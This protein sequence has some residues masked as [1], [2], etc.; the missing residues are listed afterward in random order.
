MFRNTLL[1]LLVAATAGDVQAAPAVFWAGD[2][3]R[4]GET[5][6]LIGE[7]FGE[8]PQVEVA[9]LPDGAPGAP[10]GARVAWP[11]AGRRAEVLQAG[12]QC[13]KF[14]VPAALKP[15]AFAY[16]VTGPA[17][18]TVGILNRPAIWWA[19]G[20][21][22]PA[23]SPGGRVRVLG[24]NLAAPGGG[25]GEWESGRVGEGVKGSAGR[26]AA[27]PA[28]IIALSGPT[29]VRLPAEADAY[30]A[31]AELPRK[32]PG[33]QYQLSFHNGCGG[34]SAWSESVRFAVAKRQP[35][36]DKAFNVRDFGADPTGA[37]DSTPAIQ[38]ALAGAKDGGVL[39]FPRGRYRVTDTIGVPRFTTLRG[40]AR[41]TTSLFWPDTEKPPKALVR[42]TNTFAVESLT[43]YASNHANVIVA[44]QTEPDAGDVAIRRVRVRADIYRGHLKPE[45]VHARF[46]ASLANSTGGSDSLRL[47]G[48]NVEVTDCDIYG[49][50]R[51]LFLSRV[52]G[53][54]IAGNT[55]YN[56]RWGW[57][58]ISG[59]DGLVFENNRI[60]GGDLQ[61]TG[62][63]LNC[64]DGSTCSQNVYYARNS[65][66]LMHG[67][68]REAMTSDAGGGCYYGAVASSLGS[69]V[70]LAEEPT[71]GG[72]AWAGAARFLL[73]GRGRGQYRQIV[74][75]EGKTVTLDRPWLVPPDATTTAS[76]TMLQRHY[77]FVGN[78][79]TDAGVALQ[80]YGMAIEDI[81]DGNVSTR[82]AGFH[83]FGMNYHG[84]QPSWY[85]QW[86]NNEIREGN[87]YRSGHDNYMLA[88]EAHLG[89]FGF[90]PFADYQHPITLGCVARGNALRNNAHIAIGGSDP[91]NPG[92]TLPLV[93]E[94][95]VENNSI[96]NSDV[97]I[98]LRRASRGVLLRNN[99]FQAVKEPVRDQEAAVKAAA[100]RRKQLALRREP[101]AVW[102]FEGLTATQAPD[103]TGNRF[104]ARLT[105]DVAA[106]EG[107]RGKAA[108][109]AGQSYLQVHDP[110]TFNL[111]DV[112]L[113]LWIKPDTVQGRHGLLSK[114]F[115]E[116][117][118]PYIVS[119]WD[120][121]LE[122][123]ATDAKGAWSFNFRAPAHLKAGEWAHV[124]VV[125]AAGKGVTLYANG[126][127]VGRKENPLERA[128]NGEPL[129]F[130]REAWGGS[131]Q[132]H[133]P[134]YYLGLM[135]DV[136]V[137]ARALS[138]EE[139]L[140]EFAGGG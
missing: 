73:D 54:R 70:T 34:A 67:W 51:A 125:A 19:Q 64:L 103:A 26:S 129:V 57:Y 121:D 25:V 110:E 98:S 102:D 130:G 22:G 13:V 83:N 53:G 3:I 31:W 118:A 140:R 105:G 99:R 9:R 134:C 113:S 4:P 59:S 97:G 74:R 111:Q 101:L 24:K 7:G 116:S 44:D 85:I 104:H 11:G 77:L 23:G 21:L 89:I 108:R 8:K 114:R 139:V 61:A 107:H 80:L 91:D 2:P 106:A 126:R 109:F 117:G 119:L 88:G 55:F 5:A 65:L 63:G 127:P 10:A 120:G 45:E 62:G 135:D 60:I 138:D 32:L 123:E 75:I 100:E 50:G 68:D 124:A 48:R 132:V 131:H 52:R 6:L 96:A 49:S 38:A 78:D 36:P 37:N 95:V 72:R 69:Q 18:A 33:G 90:P 27:A 81:A 20:D 94:V 122:F 115:V 35:W 137:W 16:R 29:T 136:K 40:E 58:C 71:A 28:P 92:L 93:Q 39:F 46:T 84:V 17:G 43:L 128:T 86:L 79:F 76:I 30:S 87:S 112:T 42:G 12:N 41:E 82:T 56:G 15:G 133:E 14:L 47:G 1:L 66:T